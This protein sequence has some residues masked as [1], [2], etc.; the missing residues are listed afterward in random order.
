MWHYDIFS[1]NHINFFG[2][3]LVEVTHNDCFDVHEQLLSIIIVGY[4]ILISWNHLMHLKP[5][6]FG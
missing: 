5:Y 3:K 4:L 6:S 1:A 2:I